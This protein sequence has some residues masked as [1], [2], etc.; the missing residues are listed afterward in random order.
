MNKHVKSEK[1]ISTVKLYS[2]MDKRT[3]LLVIILSAYLAAKVPDDVTPAS[4]EKAYCLLEPLY[5]VYLEWVHV[6]GIVI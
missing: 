5:K 1:K 2:L 4:K 3:R 6:N